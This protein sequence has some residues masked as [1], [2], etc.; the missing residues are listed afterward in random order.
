MELAVAVAVAVGRSR[1]RSRSSSSNSSSNSSSS[2]SSSGTS[3]GSSSASSRRGH[4]RCRSGSGDL[5]VVVAVAGVVVVVMLVFGMRRSL[6]A[7]N[8]TQASWKKTTPYSEAPRPLLAHVAVLALC[9]LEASR[10]SGVL[11]LF[12]SAVMAGRAECGAVYDAEVVIWNGLGWVRAI[13]GIVCI[14]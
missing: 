6:K 10:A 11:F 12:A 8:P 2:G 14:G 9:I 7:D 1:S 4:C 3:G 5:M 13:V